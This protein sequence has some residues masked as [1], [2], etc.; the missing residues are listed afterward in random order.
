MYFVPFHP[1]VKLLSQYCAKS[2]MCFYVI[3][4]RKTFPKRLVYSVAAMVLGAMIAARYM[5]IYIFIIIEF[6]LLIKLEIKNYNV[7]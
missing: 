1:C 5:Y 4:Y 2:V 6:E 3:S 7:F